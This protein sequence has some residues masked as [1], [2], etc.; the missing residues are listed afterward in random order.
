MDFLSIET[1]IDVFNAVVK[2]I[3]FY[4][5][6]L[7]G[8]MSIRGNPIEKVQFMFGEFNMG[9][10]RKAVNMT[11]LREL[12]LRPLKIDMQ[13]NALKCYDYIA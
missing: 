11:V 13:Q 5:S 8:C 10:H 2:P 4:G 1:I 12:G 6:E 7:W 3:L 9:V